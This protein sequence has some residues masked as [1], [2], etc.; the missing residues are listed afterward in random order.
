MVLYSKTDWPI[1]RR[2][3]HNF[4]FDFDFVFDFSH[5]SMKSPCSPLIK[6]YTQTFFMIDKKG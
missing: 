2:S 1:D 5:F 6:D 3:L 4:D